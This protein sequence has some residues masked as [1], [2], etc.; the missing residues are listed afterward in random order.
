[1]AISLKYA[2][3]PDCSLRAP[4]IPI[5]V[6]NKFGRMMK[7]LALVDSGSD[8]AV[9][10]NDMADLLELNL[11][12]ETET[13]GIG[14]MVKVRRT[15]FHFRIKN[16]RESYPLSV[17]ALVTIGNVPPI[18]GRNGFFEHFHITFKQIEQRIIFKKVV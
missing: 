7:I 14:G 1:M 8:S 4:Y 12:E 17:D 13:R 2:K 11:K 15:K 9:L 10:P 3:M 6:H 18:L 5:L 16:K